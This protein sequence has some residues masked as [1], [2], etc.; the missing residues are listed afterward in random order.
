MDEE[1]DHDNCGRFKRK[2][3]EID[4]EIQEKQE[5]AESESDFVSEVV[6]SEVID[7]KQEMI[8]SEIEEKQ[9]IIEKKASSVSERSGT[10][11]LTETM[12]SIG[13]EN[14]GVFSGVVEPQKMVAHFIDDCE[15]G[16]LQSKGHNNSLS[17]E[18]VQEKGSVAR[19]R[20]EPILEDCKISFLASEKK[21]KMV[22]DDVV[23]IY[24]SQYL[25]EEVSSLRRCQRNPESLLEVKE[26]QYVLESELKSISNAHNNDAKMKEISQEHEK[27][28]NEV[29]DTDEKL[30]G[31]PECETCV[32]EAKEAQELMEND[33]SRT[34]DF[35]G[36]EEHIENSSSSKEKGETPDTH[37]TSI[38]KHGLD[39]VKIA[40]VVVFGKG[41]ETDV[42]TD[43][44]EETSGKE[45]LSRR[46]LKAMKKA[47]VMNET[48]RV[49]N[50][51]AE[52]R[53]ICPMKPD[54]CKISYSRNE[55]DALRFVD[56]ER[57][58]TM[59]KEIYNALEPVVAKELDGMTRCKQQT[60][61]HRNVDNR[62][63]P[64]KKKGGDGILRE[65]CPPNTENNEYKEANPLDQACGVYVNPLDLS[66][67]DCVNDQND[68]TI[69]QEETIIEEVFNEDEDSEDEYE[70]IHK[71]AFLVEGEPDF[72]SGSPQDGFEYLR[73]V[74]WEAAHIPKVKV[75]K[76]DK[77]KLMS[78]QTVYM[79]K[80]PDI[81]KCPEHLLPLKEWED[82]FLS[83]F[84]ELRMALLD[85]GSTSNRYSHCMQPLV[86]AI[87]TTSL[88][89]HCDSTDLNNFEDLELFTTIDE[90]ETC[91]HLGSFGPK[92]SDNQK[93][94]TLSGMDF[95]SR[96]LMLKSHIH[97]LETKNGLSWDDCAWL[98]ALCASVDT[99]FDAD[100][101]ASM[102]SLLRKCASLRAGKSESDDEV[103]MLNI[104][105]TIAGRY[106]GQSE[107]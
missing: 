89:K 6:F 3:A 15:G 2:I 63:R 62:Q 101:S 10:G 35:N 82:S 73:R 29:Q 74:R 53:D 60:Q 46:K 65:S 94:L 20:T 24:Q 36:T 16:L 33:G 102:R 55:M 92:G 64:G 9:E 54:Q 61:R 68:C 56:V 95:I 66:C 107:G 72:D 7:E 105:V 8:V 91:Q 83:D 70:S 80:I 4:N 1:T 57:Q 87:E 34:K 5:L 26:T 47:S 19:S 37:Q 21:G 38:S 31:G 99:P 39:C 18:W 28:E 50:L 104:L 78:D 41:S 103:V 77:T 69:I 22:Q 90:V 40:R 30:N 88:Q 85:I 93:L 86:T 59:W 32:S 27:L 12:D 98:F 14:T 100:M 106:F 67:G 96:A 44:K 42:K 75:A 81:A 58:Q 71:L 97:S 43:V 49:L 17:E 52:V 13:C 84:S 25:V 23:S 76:L 48:R 45:K 79:P 51:W 11:L